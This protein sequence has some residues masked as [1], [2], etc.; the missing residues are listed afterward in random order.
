MKPGP[1]DPRGHQRDGRWSI[2]KETPE[3]LVVR[4]IG[5]VSFYAKRG[6]H[7]GNL[8]M[9]VMEGLAH[10]ENSQREAVPS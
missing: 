9:R 2:E 4:L 1:G 6:P 3:E 5:V 10:K 8:A 7:G